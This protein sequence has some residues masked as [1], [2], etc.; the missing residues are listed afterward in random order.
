MNVKQQSVHERLAH[1]Q[2]MPEARLFVHDIHVTHSPGCVESGL[3]RLGFNDSIIP[4]SSGSKRG[5]PVGDQLLRSGFLHWCRKETMVGPDGMSIDRGGGH[6]QA[7][8]VLKVG[9]AA[10]VPKRAQ[11]R[12][13]AGSKLRWRDGFATAHADQAGSDHKRNA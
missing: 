8:N 2:N 6:A 13:G 5:K 3:V 12:S 1:G 7:G 10:R 4:V 11:G 9:P